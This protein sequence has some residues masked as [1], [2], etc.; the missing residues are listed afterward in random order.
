MTERRGEPA[1]LSGVPGK[2]GLSDVDAVSGTEAWAAGTSFRASAAPTRWSPAGTVPPGR[3]NPRRTAIRPVAASLS[4]VAAAGGTVWAVGTYHRAGPS[5]NRRALILQ[6]TGGI[7]R[8]SPR[9]GCREP[10]SSTA[11]T[12]PG[13]RTPGRSA[14]APPTSPARPAYRS[15]CAGT[16]PVAVESLPAPAVRAVRGR[17]ADTHQRVGGRAALSES[18]LQPYVAHFNGTSWRRVATPTLDGGGQLTDI[19]ALSPSNIV[20]VGTA[21]TAVPRSCCT[22]TARHGRMRRHRTRSTSTGAAAVGPNTFWAVGHRLRPQR[23][24]GADVH[25]GSDLTARG[26]AGGPAF[27]AAGAVGIGVGGP[28][29]TV[30]SAGGVGSTVAVGAGVVAVGRGA[31]GLV[32]VAP[33]TSRDVAHIGPPDVRRG[34]QRADRVAGQ[35]VRQDPPAHRARDS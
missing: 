28:V 2:G 18:G 35:R 27:W 15:C 4:G 12:P 25:D 33:P 10:S 20:A 30:V 24:R 19:V 32:G 8:V 16:A 34:R 23:V 21:G 29:G 17:R 9:R 11:S 13:R 3:R 22:G 6:R 26:S 7:W 5:Y 31:G 1:P 14:G